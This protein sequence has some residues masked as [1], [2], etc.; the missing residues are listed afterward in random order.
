MRQPRDD[1]QTTTA[2]ALWEINWRGKLH[3][4]T[5]QQ[6]DAQPH[7]WKYAR[8]MQSGDVLTFDTDFEDDP[9]PG[10][11][12]S[13]SRR[14]SMPAVPPP[15]LVED[16][17]YIV[18]RKRASAAAP[19]TENVPRKAKKRRGG[20]VGQFRAHP[21]LILGIGMLLMLGLW[22]GLSW[23]ASWWTVTLDDWHF[24]RPRTAQYDVVVGHDDSAANPTHIIAEN[25]HGRVIL[26]EMPGGDYTK[27]KIY[28]GP[29]LFGPNSD[30][31]PVTLTF[32][33][34]DNTGHP[35][36]LIHVQDATLIYQ[37]EKVNGVWQFVSPQIQ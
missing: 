27:A 19:E 15:P 35:M 3:T 5:R 25:L 20:L 10:R 14:Y 2:E 30:L 9:H 31:A 6:L 23:L 8:P 28:K 12:P 11:L 36:M 17:E 4:F 1:V 26:I 13:S 22:V 21:L 33:D 24:G 16:R 34:P 18:P 7:L 32:S 37:N 29:T